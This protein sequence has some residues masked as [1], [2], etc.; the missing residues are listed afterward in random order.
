MTSVLVLLAVLA[1]AGGWLA[2]PLHHFTAPVWVHAEHHASEEAHHHAHNLAMV[3]STVVGALGI[4]LA[5]FLYGTQRKALQS[6][7]EGPGRALHEVMANKFYVDEIYEALV[8]RPI[9]ALARGL[10]AAVDRFIVDGW[11]VEGPG[12]VVMTVGQLARAGQ[13]GAVSV[14]TAATLVGAVVVL[15][16]MVVNG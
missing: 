10:Y 5:V 4:G 14:A 12:L 2:E 11:M 6:F 8:V 9:G 13:V 15:L 7:V 3:T 1:T 16:W